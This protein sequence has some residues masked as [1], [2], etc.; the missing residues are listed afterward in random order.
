MKNMKRKNLFKKLFK[1]GDLM[2]KV[3]DILQKSAETTVDLI[4]IF[5]SS[6]YES[7]RKMRKS[8]LYGSPK[9]KTDWAEEYLKNQQFYSLLNKLKNQG[10]IKKEEKNKKTIWSITQKGLEK[11]KIIKEKRK[12]KLNYP[13]EKSNT[14]III[15]FDIPEQEKHKREW[16]RSVLVALDFK[17][18]QKSVWIG[19][20]KIPEEF[21]KDLR[22]QKILNYVHIFKVSKGG[23]I[24]KFK[25]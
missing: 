24:N 2:V 4:D 23:T 3:L 25:L 16:L 19:K 12:R 5:T 8:M 6:Y 15:T 13:K 18:L 9:F 1:K 14:L 11:L 7:Y 17:L 20:N 21:L 22:E 10:F